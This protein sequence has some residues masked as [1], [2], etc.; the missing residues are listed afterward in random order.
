MYRLQLS[1]PT[2]LHTAIGPGPGPG[3][4]GSFS[5][6]DVIFHFRNETILFCLADIYI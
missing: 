6:K 5:A 3:G 4:G 1:L 2:D